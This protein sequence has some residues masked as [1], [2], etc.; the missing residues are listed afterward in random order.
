MRKLGAE[1]DLR[2]LDD[3]WVVP[4]GLLLV[5][6]PWSGLPPLGLACRLLAFR[7]RGLPR[8]SRLNIVESRSP[9]PVLPV[10]PVCRLQLWLWVGAVCISFADSVVVAWR[11]LLL[12]G[13]FS[14]GLRSP[15]CCRLGCRRM[16][17]VAWVAAAWRMG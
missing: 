12:Q 9:V 1:R 6:W 5:D 14:A 10:L 16:T 17:T 11:C 3:L 7:L 4:L 2:A 15:D 8:P 13:L